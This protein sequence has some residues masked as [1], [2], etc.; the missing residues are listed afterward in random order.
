[1]HV[2]WIVLLVLLLLFLGASA[3]LYWALRR[4]GYQRW[5]PAYCRDR[6]RRR[7]P[8]PGQN[9]H[10]FLCFADHYEPKYHADKEIG[11]ARVRHWVETFPRN[12]G[13]FRDSDGRP[14]RYTFFFPI[15][16][17]EPEYLDLLAE[18]CRQGYG[19]VEVHLHHDDDTAEGFRDKLTAFIDL[20]DKRHGLLARRRDDGKLVYGFIHG[21]WALCNARPDGKCCGVNNELAILHETGCYAD[22]TFPSAPHFTQPP[23]INRLYYAWDRPGQPCS[24]EHGLETGTGSPPKDALLMV[25]GPLLLQW[26]KRKWGV[27]PKLEN[28]CLQG[29]QPPHPERLDAWLRARIQVPQ[30]PDWFFV[31][32][33]AHGA[34]EDAH[35]V[36]LGEPMIRF[37]EALAERAKD[38]PRFHYHY[39]TARELY[40][41][42]KAAE[43]GFQGTVEKARD[44]LLVS[45]LN[46][47]PA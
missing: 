7:P 18:F 21:N 1:M 17:Y 13:R 16:E 20:L 4:R 37:H 40:N 29:T 35:E 46:A 26:R 14:P 32:L 41:L 6:A 24:H 28:G 8:D 5:L 9:T 43:A 2:I 15:E 27:L 38:D 11:L 30:R 3:A 47:P 25:Q 10:L 22:F 31:K 36:L 42:V 39:V 33:H 34:P 23:I 12:L 45:N 44:F 19:E